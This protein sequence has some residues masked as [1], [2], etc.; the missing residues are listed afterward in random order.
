MEAIGVYFSSIEFFFCPVFIKVLTF[1]KNETI[2]EVKIKI[3][4]DEER[5]MREAF[6]VHLTRDK[7][8]VAI[9]DND[10]TIVY[11]EENLHRT[12]VTFPL[13]PT[14]VSLKDYDDISKADAK[15][16][17]GY[18]LIC[19]TVSLCNVLFHMLN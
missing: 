7:N 16:I 4:H 8:R 3:L 5:E 13:I 17:Q 19:V 10:K 14:V 12:G 11:I 18:P 6:T 15:P 2:V 9:I 1:E